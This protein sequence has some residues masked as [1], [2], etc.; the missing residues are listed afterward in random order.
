MIIANHNEGLL[1]TKWW[2]YPA[3]PSAFLCSLIVICYNNYMP[4]A[5]V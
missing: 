2:Y 1:T 5:F 4:S 3:M